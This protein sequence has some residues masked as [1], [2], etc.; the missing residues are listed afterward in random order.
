MVGRGATRSE[1]GRR[2]RGDCRGD[3]RVGEAVG[4][5]AGTARRAL[6]GAETVGRGRR[7]RE[8]G[9]RGVASA[10]GDGGG[11]ESGARG[12]RARGVLSGRAAR[13]RRTACGSHAATVRCR[14]GPA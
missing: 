5:R 3:G 14:T 11:T 8:T 7:G 13:M 6:S 1:G 4:R 2:G 12:Q 9:G 10:V